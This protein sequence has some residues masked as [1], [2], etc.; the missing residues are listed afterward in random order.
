MRHG[1]LRSSRYSPGNMTRE[2]LEALFVGRGDLMED[3]L[4]RVGTSIRSPEKHYVLLVGPRGSGKTHFIALACHRLMDR[5]DTAS[6]RD[7][8]AVAL[9]NEE[10]W[11]VASFLDLVVR[12]LRALAD[13]AP[14]LDA[15]IAGIY[16]RFSKDPAN[17]EAFA[18]A[19]LRQHTSGKTLLLLCENLV[20]LFHG[21]GEEGQKRWRATIQEDGNWA[22]V[23]STPSLFAAVTLQDNPFYGFFTIR[24]L[25]KIDFDTGLDLLVKK[26]V[27]EDKRELADFLRTPLGRARARAIHHL[28]AGNHRA[29]VVLF[30]FLDKESLDDLVRPFMDMVDDLT[31][32]YQDRM[33]QL[34]PAQRKIVEFLCLQGKPTTIKN[35]STPCLMSQQTAAKQIGE[36]RAA[37]FVSRTRIGRN[38]YCELSEP[39]MRICIE[40]KDNKT[41]HFRLFVEF[42]R[43]WFT[44]RELERRHAAFLHDDHGAKLDRVH[45]EEAVRRSRADRFEPFADALHVEA[46]RCWDADDYPGLAT[47]QETLV[48][49]SGRAEDYRVWVLA[50][51]EAGDTQAAIAAGR[52]AVA[53]YPDDADLHYWLTHAFFEEDRLVEALAT[54]DRAIAIDGED[55]A[56]PCLRADVLL[57]LGQFEEALAAIDRAITIDGARPSYCCLRADVLFK[58]GQFEEALA[59]IDQAIAIDGAK[60]SYHCLRAGALLKLDQF[61]EAIREA[62]AV[63]DME[64]DHWH[65]F[66]QMIDAAVAM[67]RL[68]DAEAHAKELVRLA[69]AEPAA[70]LTA[71]E[72]Y[73]SQDRLD[74]ALELVD[75][76]L[77]ID[78]DDHEARNL[79]GFILF[80]M[81]DYRRASEELRRSASHHRG[82]VSTHCRLADSLLLSGEWEEAV[83]VAEHLI[84]IDPMHHHAHYVR[85]EAL[86]ELGRPADAIAA[87]DELLPMNGCHSLLLAASCVREIGDYAS[88]ARYLERVAELQPDNRELWIERTRLHI[89]E[90]AFDAAAESA[91]RIAALPGGLLLGRLFAAQAAA[92]TEP[93][94]VVLDTLG[95][96]L[97]RKDFGS[98]E[99]RHLEAT[100]GILTV[101]L[102]S[103]GPRHLPQGLAKLRDLLTDRIEGGVVGRILTDFL[104]ANV[105]DGFTGSLADWERA[106]EDIADSP[107]AKL[108]DC[109]IPVEMLQVAVRYTKTGDERHLLSLP[110]EQRQL[111]ESVL[112]PAAG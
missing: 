89:D 60:P 49:D 32:Y 93:L 96:V 65:S 63:L 42:L 7:R 47:I 51:V 102:R 110:L 58:L 59:A 14:D 43:H 111:L 72:F 85:G 44:N 71:S 50:L 75:K 2:S 95:A 17:A 24:A 109:S 25:E 30:D 1:F 37:G 67:G 64:P 80:E 29:Y 34:P 31:P 112:P 62:Q 69:P 73:R 18:V 15:E 106:L 83:D 56:Y 66:G 97:E 27:H 55:S 22:I 5:L 10:E 100:V 26:A 103:F 99:K 98:D 8:V 23:A 20:D 53:K 21:L 92:A 91:A 39:L 86:V 74:Q 61:E 12:I 57:K 36:L 6:A 87:F 88:A 94:P 105:D 13:R 40:V 70:L 78:A 28:A 11:G 90:R 81:E 104:K 9:L 33:R 84:E 77:G 3:V 46:E 48:Q 41:R 68:Q 38:T 19:R 16:D 45:V 108:R 4:S 35:I 101:S 107:L 82:S 54:I 76:T 79:R 52:E